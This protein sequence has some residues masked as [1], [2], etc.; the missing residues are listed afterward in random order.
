[1]HVFIYQIRI[2]YTHCT[3][4]QMYRHEGKHQRVKIIH[5]KSCMYVLCTPS[6]LK[7]LLLAMRKQD[8]TT[9]NVTHV[10]L[11]ET[12][13]MIS[14]YHHLFPLIS[15]LKIF[16]YPFGL[17]NALP[18]HTIFLLWSTILLEGFVCALV[19]TFSFQVGSFSPK[20]QIE[21]FNDNNKDDD[22]IPSPF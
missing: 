19:Q 17:S 4:Y 21:G 22:Q 6:S 18:P 20:K 13:L 9:I 12:C 15:Y 8:T 2:K 11:V 10:Q 5:D 3:K 7:I 14:F 1:M 16:S